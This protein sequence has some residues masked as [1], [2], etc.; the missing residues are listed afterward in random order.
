MANLSIE[1]HGSGDPIL[2]IHGLGGTSN[3]FTPQVDVLSRF[4]TCLR[5]DL[6]G[7]GRSPLSG[8]ISIESLVTAA[9]DVIDAA[10]GQRPVH[11]IAHSMGTV[12]AQHLALRAPQ[13]VRTLSLI[14]PLH[15]PTDVVRQ[16]VRARAAIARTEGMRPIADAIV[17]GGI[18]ADTRAHL[19]AVAAFVREII[20][21]QDAEGYAC[22]C[23]AL[24]AAEPAQLGQIAQPTL[25]ITGDEDSTSPAMAVAGLARQM[26]RARLKILSRCGHWASL[27][28]PLEVSEALIGFLTGG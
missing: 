18:A 6:P 2:F 27:E 23:E 16:A 24:A 4:F 7:A 5:P 17:Q 1:V 8:R 12:I 25:L 19:P 10:E 13:K 28:R 9:L 11:L 14:G 3:V 22:H 26:P 20:M 15:A 21:R